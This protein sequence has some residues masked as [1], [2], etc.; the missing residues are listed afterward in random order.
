M[1]AAEKFTAMGFPVAAPL[2]EHAGLETITLD[3]LTDPHVCIGNSVHVVLTAVTLLVALACVKKGGAPPPPLPPPPPEAPD[4]DADPPETAFP[5]QRDLK[6]L[7]ASVKYDGRSKAFKVV[8]RDL[9]ERLF[10]VVHWDNW[11]TAQEAALND[12]KALNL[13]FDELTALNLQELRAECALLGKAGGINRLTKAQAAEFIMT[14]TYDAPTA[15][16]L[17][18]SAAAAS[19]VAGLSVPRSLTFTIPSFHA[20]VFLDKFFIAVR[21]HLYRS[22]AGFG[23]NLKNRCFTRLDVSGTTVVMQLFTEPPP[24]CLAKRDADLVLAGDTSLW[25]GSFCI[26]HFLLYTNSPTRGTQIPL[27]F[28]LGASHTV[29]KTKRVTLAAMLSCPFVAVNNL[30]DALRFQ[31]GAVGLTHTFSYVRTCVNV[32]PNY[33][34]LPKTVFILGYIRGSQSGQTPPSAVSGCLP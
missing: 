31:S 16:P 27:G 34:G 13:R 12:L 32:F 17:E 7:P 29:S 20:D 23:D 11:R 10:K 4:D 2:A 3:D 1:T 22:I 30:G 25:I 18:T 8:F 5:R 28:V 24:I 21:T 14:A 33:I 6:G 19:A 9:K 26:N 15:G